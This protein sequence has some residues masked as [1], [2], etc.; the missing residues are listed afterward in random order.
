MYSFKIREE[1][2]HRF[3]RMYVFQR[4]VRMDYG[5]FLAALQN[6]DFRDPFMALLRD[7]E[8]PA[9]RWETPSLRLATR[10]QPF[11]FVFVNSPEIDVP[12]EP[13]VFARYYSDAVDG[14]VEFTNLGG[15]AHLI[16]P[17]PVTATSDYAH[18]GKFMRSAANVQVHALWDKVAK[19]MAQAISEQPL[20]LSTAG[21]G[22]S[23][24]HVRID[25][26]PKYYRYSLYRKAT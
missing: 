8:Y 1:K 26:R 4:N 3:Q 22:V 11:E 18:L 9:Y 12:P 16:V 7:C 2:K 19:T 23:W 20:W 24:L 21:G 14:I 5:M 13:K 10:Q 17:T 25:Q 15:D 6:S